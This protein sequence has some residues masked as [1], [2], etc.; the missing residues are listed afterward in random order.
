MKEWETE[1]KKWLNSEVF[2]EQTKI[3]LKS[4]ND[5]SELED[6]FYKDLSFGTG[7]MRGII[8]A[9]RNR[10]N[11][12]T[13]SRATQ[14]LA[15]FINKTVKGGSVVV[16]FDSRNKSPEFA[17]VTALTL[18][19]NGIKVYLFDILRPV[20]ELSFSV[21]ALSATAGVEITASHNPPE[22]NG[23][24]VFWSD[25]GQVVA[26]YD[27]L[28]MESVHLVKDFGS[29]KTMDRKS[30]EKLGLLTVIGKE[31]DDKYIA[32]LK[33]NI[34]DKEVIKKHAEDFTIVYTPLN[35]AGNLPVR[36]L[37]SELG[38]KKV[39]V[40]KEQEAP[41]GNFPTLKSPN[42][43]NA[44]AFTLAL[45][46]AEKVKA[47]IVLATDP[48]S[49]RLGV[50]ALDKRTNSYVSFTGNMSGLLIAEYELSRMQE[51][52]M[53]PENRCDGA[54]V[55]TIV[56]SKMAYKIAEFYGVSVIETLTGFKFIGEQIKLFEDA[57]KNNGGKYSAEKYA[58]KYLFGYEESYGC[59]VGTHSRDK[60]GV[61][62]VA[63]L[64]EAA[65]Y[66]LDKGL[67]LPEQMD[68]IFRKYGYYKEGIISVTMPGVSGAEKIKSL[69]EKLRVDTPIKV[70]EDKVIAVR[71]Y[72]L[73]ERKDIKTGE[74]VK[75]TLPKSNV[76]YFELENNGWCAIRPS[77]TEPKI[78]VYFGVSSDSDELS[79]FKVEK[80]K[81]YFTDFL[82]KQG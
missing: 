25:G 61:M 69:I 71:D 15:D 27:K 35:G 46:L 29:V 60:D 38:F 17:L 67:T 12:Y 2:D 40:V 20:P 24:K 34:I 81:E 50:Y 54:I 75:L 66:Y 72:N 82:E 21:R 47:D 30:A 18:C 76:L 7:G 32:E 28:I 63:A 49:D 23:Y 26:P 68:N 51:L 79:K 11:K 73:S 8:G 57:I 41:D 14:G 6:R 39:F 45:S 48:D 31:L 42:P 10:M 4:I 43:E 59:L 53:L 56:S 77:G 9:G 74:K 37:L 65:C 80:I 5:E 58:Y 44:S 19:A 3:E 62:A 70:G 33:N 22:Y 52:N 78:K 13:V 55:T 1:Y 36:R 64:C 16:A